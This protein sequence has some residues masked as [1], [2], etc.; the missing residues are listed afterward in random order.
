VKPVGQSFFDALPAGA[1]VCLVEC[2]T[3]GRIA[4]SGNSAADA[5]KRAR[6]SGTQKARSSK[7]LKI[8]GLGGRQAAYLG[9]FRELARASG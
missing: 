9:E 7:Y 1:N 8:D 2:A 3:A 4:S 6:P 5:P